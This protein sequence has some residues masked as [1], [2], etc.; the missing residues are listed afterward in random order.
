MATSLFLSCCLLTQDTATLLAQEK[1]RLAKEVAA[2]A[3]AADRLASLTTRLTQ[4]RQ[5]DASL[6]LQQ[7][8]QAYSEMA[9]TYPEEYIMYSLAA[10]AL[11]QVQLRMRALMAGVWQAGAGSSR[12]EPFV[13]VA[14][15]CCAC[16][17]CYFLLAHSCQQLMAPTFPRV[18]RPQQV[19]SQRCPQ[20]GMCGMVA[21]SCL[22]TPQLALLHRL[23]AAA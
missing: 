6:S 21:V 4:V 15:G 7:L 23:A 12:L 10:A 13:P 8:L 14:D 5:H 11:A 2:A 16:S 3:A 1:E 19:L 18:Q 17:N 20:A 22:H 9:G